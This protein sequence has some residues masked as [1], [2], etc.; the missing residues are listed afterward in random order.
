VQAEGHGGGGGFVERVA[1]VVQIE[2]VQPTEAADAVAAFDEVAQALNLIARAAQD[3]F[4]RRYRRRG[5]WL[6]TWRSVLGIGHTRTETVLDAAV[7]GDLMPAVEEDDFVF[8]GTQLKRAVEQG[9]GRRVAVAVETDESLV[10]DHAHF[11]GVHV[12]DVGG[13]RVQGGF[14]SGPPLDGPRP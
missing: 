3:G 4:L 5:A 12:R 8:V 1:R 10:I 6:A 9:R 7:L 11:E 14:L 2:A 13:Q